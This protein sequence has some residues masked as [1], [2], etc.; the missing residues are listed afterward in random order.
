MRAGVHI[1]VKV[2]NAT[3]NS[4]Q[5]LPKQ[6]LTNSSKETKPDETQNVQNMTDHAKVQE[7]MR[8]LPAHKAANNNTAEIAADGAAT[9]NQSKSLPPKSEDLKRPAILLTSATHARELIT[10]QYSMY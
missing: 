2:G 8:S 5:E 6:G 9:A 1:D 3:E 10:I 7:L 4:A